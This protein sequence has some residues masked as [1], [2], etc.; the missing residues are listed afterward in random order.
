[1]KNLKYFIGI[2][3]LVISVSS[4]SQLKVNSS[5]TVGIGIDPVSTYNLRLNTAIFVTGSG[6]SDMIVIMTRQATE[7]RFTQAPII[8]A[9]WERQTT[10]L[11]RFMHCTIIP[12]QHIIFLT[13]D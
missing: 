1:M 11:Q 5:G 13:P 9:G 4:Y 7:E 3:F 6:Y 2:I 8:S 12:G 10:S